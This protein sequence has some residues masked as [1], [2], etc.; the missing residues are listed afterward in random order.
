MKVHHNRINSVGQEMFKKTF[1]IDL[2]SDPN[3]AIKRDLY[4][5]SYRA[6]GITIISHCKDIPL[7]H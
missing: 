7:A 5:L 1:R 4:L 2:S 3:P 6:V